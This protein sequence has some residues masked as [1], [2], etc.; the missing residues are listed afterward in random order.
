MNQ[1]PNGTGKAVSRFQLPKRLKKIDFTEYHPEM[2]NQ[3]VTVWIN[4]TREVK[5]EFFRLTAQS[6]LTEGKQLEN[7]S[8]TAARTYVQELQRVGEAE[9]FKQLLDLAEAEA[10]ADDQPFTRHT[11]KRQKDRLKARLE[12][13][14]ALLEK[15]DLAVDDTTVPFSLELIDQEAAEVNAGIDAWYSNILSQSPDPD[16]HVSAEEFNDLA[17]STRAVEPKFF[18]WLVGAIQGEIKEFREGQKKG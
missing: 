16:D 2:I 18:E 6:E 13:S 9:G 10:I 8:V 17:T 3:S 4:P 11:R 12:E 15:H 1:G 14:M 7:I 5:E